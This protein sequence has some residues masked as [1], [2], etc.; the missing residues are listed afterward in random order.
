MAIPSKLTDQWGL[1][2]GDLLVLSAILE[3]LLDIYGSDMFMQIS[4]KESSVCIEAL[5]CHRWTEEGWK[6]LACLASQG[7]DEKRVDR[8]TLESV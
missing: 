4:C 5:H 2:V 1:E 3:F 8:L 6:S 7:R